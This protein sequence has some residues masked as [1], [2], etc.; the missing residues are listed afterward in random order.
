MEG[1]EG[2]VAV[3]K[4]PAPPE[5]K[6]K[7]PISVRVVPRM[8]LRV[9]DFTVQHFPRQTVAKQSKSRHPETQRFESQALCSWDQEALNVGAQAGVLD[10]FAVKLGPHIIMIVDCCCPG[11]ISCGAGS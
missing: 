8:W 5:I 7:K 3:G 4:G 9:F 1:F 2:F 6:C 10:D 11:D